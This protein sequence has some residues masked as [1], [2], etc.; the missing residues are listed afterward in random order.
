MPLN[1]NQRA[2]A[3]DL[4]LDMGPLQRERFSRFVQHRIEVQN[5]HGD[6]EGTEEEFINDPS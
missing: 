6:P 3:R 2:Q 5:T 1:Q 4:V